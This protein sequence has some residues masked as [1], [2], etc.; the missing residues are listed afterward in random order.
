MKQAGVADHD[1]AGAGTLELEDVPI[2]I[3]HPHFLDERVQERVERD[4]LGAQPGFPRLDPVHRQ[5][6]IQHLRHAPERL[7]DAHADLRPFAR[8][9]TVNLAGQEVGRCQQCGHGRAELMRGHRHEAGLHLGNLPFL[10]QGGRHLLVG[11]AAVADVPNEDDKLVRQERR[12]TNFDRNRAG[13][14]R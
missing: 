4:R 2:G 9:Q 6:V 1:D 11:P 10:A 3:T 12:G 14:S 13:Y 7:M 8:T 5:Q